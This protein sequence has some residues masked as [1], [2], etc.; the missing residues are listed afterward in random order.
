MV[1]DPG[2]VAQAE[3]FV[4]GIGIRVVKGHCYLEGFI[5]DRE[6]EERWL[7]DKVMGWAES[8]ETLAGVSC[9]YPQS[10]YVGLQKSIQKE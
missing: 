2:N 5:G 7:G 8:V 9:K 1:V 6:V 4:Q 10:A 3:E